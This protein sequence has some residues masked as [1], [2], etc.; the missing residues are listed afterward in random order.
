MKN[1]EV[2]A[3]NVQTD[4]LFSIE[5]RPITKVRKY[6]KMFFFIS[7]MAGIGLFLNSCMEGYVATQPTYVEYSR[8]QRPSELHVWVDGDWAYNRSTRVYVQKNG[9]WQQPRQNRTYV[10]GHWQS[11]PRGHY[12]VSGRYQRQG[13]HGNRHS[14]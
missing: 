11:S 6:M 7:S 1:N 13:H 8:P 5:T 10:S 2:L 4:A 9:Y 3:T 12:W 14:R